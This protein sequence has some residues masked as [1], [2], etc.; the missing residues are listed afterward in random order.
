MKNR[1]LL[2]AAAAM[3]IAGMPAQAAAQTCITRAEIAG[4]MG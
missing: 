4:M 1:G 2:A 3:A